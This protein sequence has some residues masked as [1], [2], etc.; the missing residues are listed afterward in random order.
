MRVKSGEYTFRTK[1]LT[2]CEGSPLSPCEIAD[3]AFESFLKHR[4]KVWR[5]FSKENE[6]VPLSKTAYS[7]QSFGKAM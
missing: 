6:E 5:L 7:L 1:S 2:L 3:L 4:T